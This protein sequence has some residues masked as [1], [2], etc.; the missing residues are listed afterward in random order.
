MLA[1][2]RLRRISAALVLQY[3]PARRPMSDSSQVKPKKLVK[4]IQ[5]NNI[6]AE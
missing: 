2:P 1:E 6:K 5:A 3:W 4:V